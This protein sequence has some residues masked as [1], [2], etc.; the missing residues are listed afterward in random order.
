MSLRS[1]SGKS[2]QA[3][4]SLALTGGSVSRGTGQPSTASAQAFQ[5][6]ATE[7]RAVLFDASAVVSAR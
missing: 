5:V 2:S 6:R 7:R 1:P 4:P 3:G